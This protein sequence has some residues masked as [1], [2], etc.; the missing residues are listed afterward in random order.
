MF[1][2][3]IPEVSTKINNLNTFLTDSIK[4]HRV[5]RTRGYAGPGL[6]KYVKHFYNFLKYVEAWP[7]Q[8][9]A[10]KRVH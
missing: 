4:H 9:E 10:I 2:F 3:F 5:G 1:R 7:I 8:F 6:L